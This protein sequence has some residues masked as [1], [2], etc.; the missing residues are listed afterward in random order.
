MTIRKGELVVEILEEK[1][2]C[3]DDFC[4]V[5]C[6]DN[7]KPTG[8]EQR[9][10]TVKSNASPGQLED[11]KTYRFWGQWKTTKYGKQFD[12]DT[13]VRALPLDERGMKLY[14]QRCEGI[15]PAKATKIIQAF[16]QGSL[17]AVRTNPLEVHNQ[18]GI[19]RHALERAALLLE[20]DSGR[21]AIQ[22]ELIGLL[23]GR[24]FRKDLPA[25]LLTRF[26]NR[27][28]ELVR[29]DPFVLL[30]F[31]SCGF[32][33]VDKMYLD[34]G[35]DPRSERR[36]AL[37]LWHGFDTGMDGSTWYSAADGAAALD[38][39]IGTGADLATAAKAGLDQD[40]LDSLRIH[41]EV[42]MTSKTRA[43][44]ERRIVD[45]ITR[46]TMSHRHSWPRVSALE[47]LS[48]HQAT[49][50]QRALSA[51]IAAF[52]GS[53][54][55]GKSFTIARLVRLIMSRQD[56]G[57]SL[58]IMA[59][60]GKAA[61]RM[62]ELFD[63]AGIAARAKTIHSSLGVM[64]YARGVFE[65][66]HTED[67]P[68]PAKFVIVDESSM[69]DAP[70]M[71]ALLAALPEDGH[72]LL[73]GDLN[74]L[75]P[76][77]HGKPLADLVESGAVP[78]GELREIRRNSGAI[79][80]TCA[81]IRDDVELELPDRIDR[82]SGGNLMLFD[83]STKAVTGNICSLL[84]HLGSNRGVN[85]VWDC[86][87]IVAL[88]ERGD[89]SRRSVNELL[90]RTFNDTNRDDPA[91]G[92]LWVDDKVVCL[93]N[94]FLPGDPIMKHATDE[95]SEELDGFLREKSMEQFDVYVANGEI[96]RVLTVETNRVRM[97]FFSPQRVVYYPRKPWQ[98][99]EGFELGYAVSCHK[100]QGSQWPIVIIGLD[101]S[102][103][104]RIVCDRSWIYTAISRARDECYLIGR[105]E[106]IEQM[107]REN[108]IDR[109]RT[110]LAAR[111]KEAC[112]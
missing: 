88:N 84:Q 39:R 110:F 30:E 21:E 19:D 25:F 67:D 90:Q 83:T 102:G 33:K 100:A 36:Q 101:D 62:N 57:A 20:E 28:A 17:Q 14:L 15:G 105:A 104:A 31:P 47:E 10:V 16:G 41:G 46:R 49:E 40:L 85:P 37:A 50:L 27:A 7:T 61:V 5:K 68:L 34:L 103:G 35:G 63:E 75:A 96:G 89:L 81:A 58:R 45:E 94:Q 52:L 93:R 13:F 60:T 107:R 95:E 77:G 109:R 54:G 4:I 51:P 99:I 87:V 59:P 11:G 108:R 66:E 111:I 69:I 2:R 1:I 24:G 91:R 22:V 18:T 78:F 98:P 53:P 65:F 9:Y 42:F 12:A 92:A 44:H 38:H 8:G 82:D 43:A 26:G 70:I 79:V 71:A 106:T 86:Q 73:V 29:N 23:A 48:D 76:V 112:R 64:G 56:D 74:Q 97:Q 72:L 55:T 80:E 32:V 3:G 6:I